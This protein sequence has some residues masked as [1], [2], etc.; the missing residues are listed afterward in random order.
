MSSPTGTNPKSC[1]LRLAPKRSLAPALSFNPKSYTA[2]VRPGALNPQ[3]CALRSAP[4]RS[5]APAL[6]GGMNAALPRSFDPPGGGLGPG[7]W[8]GG[9][10]SGQVPVM[11]P[12]PAPGEPLKGP[13]R[14]ADEGGAGVPPAWP[15]ARAPCVLPFASRIPRREVRPP[16]VN[17][18]SLSAVFLA[19]SRLK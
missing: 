6:A 9:S 16:L 5:L 3:S 7:R 12:G 10:A 1:A 13:I 11:S 8:S 2:A 15:L 18:P 17:P 19:V 4:A 14:R